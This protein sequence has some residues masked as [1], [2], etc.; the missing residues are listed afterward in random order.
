MDGESRLGAAAPDSVRH[1]V[2]AVQMYPLPPGTSVDDDGH[3]W[4]GGCDGV[5]LVQQ[6]GTPLYVFN[7]DTVRVRCRA[8]VEAFASYEPGAT[9]AYAAKAFLTRAMAA[10][11]ASEGLHLDIVSGGELYIALTAGFPA[12][13]MLFHGNNKSLAEIEM[14]V[15]A[16][17]ARFVVD[18]FNELELLERVTARKNAVQGVLL[19]VAPGLEAHTHAYIQTGAQ[20]SK[21]GFDLESGQALEAA[22]RC[23]QS[24]HLH[25][26]GLHAHV[27][28]QLLDVTVIPP[29]VERLLDLAVAVAEATGVAVRELNI[30]GG[31]GIRY[32]SEQALD[33]AVVARAATTAVC[34]GCE[35]RRF[36]LP[37]LGV[38]P[39]RS[40]VGEAAVA[41]YTVG[42]EKRVPGMVPYVAVDGGMGDN[43]RPAL[44]G[45]AY[46][47]VA[48]GRVHDPCTERVHI[49]GRFCE[50]GDFL[51]REVLLPRLG[52]GD[53]VAVYSAGAYQYPMASNYNAV[54]RPCVL[55]VRGDSVSVMVK[56]ESY[57]DLLARDVLPAYLMTERIRP[58]GGQLAA[59]WSEG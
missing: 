22:R 23:S 9:V 4:I 44:Y 58:A 11:V 39:G 8:W 25:L 26:L 55:L 3:L 59:P 14:A 17:V 13:R 5:E 35:R 27:G 21:F 20:D 38:E 32:R 57:E 37:R 19:R 46:A 33:P 47:V 15:D 43:I 1:G 51:A 24:Q 54:P 48:A 29:L 45:A 53:V 10:I 31:A 12:Q 34:T 2:T 28:S 16:G 52:P 36:P 30:G 41:L 42:S 18:N 6:Y 50:S 56:R 40:I 49:V 7:E